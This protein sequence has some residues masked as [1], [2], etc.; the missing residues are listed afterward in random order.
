MARRIRRSIKARSNYSRENKGAFFQVGTTLTNGLYQGGTLIVPPSTVQG[1][2]TV[3]NFTITVPVTGNVNSEYWWALVYVPQSQVA[4]PLF[5]ATGSPDGSL[6]EPNQYV[7]ASGMT[8]N[9]AGP[10]RIRTKMSRKLH[11]GDF[12]SLIVGTTGDQQGTNPVKGLVSYSI[13]YN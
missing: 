8:D 13:R 1:T 3:K 6:Y 7:I 11:S 5:A 2:R 10:I 9:S 12:I 4:Q